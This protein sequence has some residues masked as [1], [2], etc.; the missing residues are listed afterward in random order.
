M[1]ELGIPRP[2]EVPRI[3]GKSSKRDWFRPAPEKGKTTLHKWVCPDCGLNVRI[4]IGSD[5]HLV[6]D[7]CSEIRGEKVFLVR[8]DGL[9]HTIYENK[10][11][12]NLEEA[13][14]PASPISDLVED[15]K[16]AKTKKEKGAIPPI[17]NEINEHLKKSMKRGLSVQGLAKKAGISKARLRDWLKSDS[18]FTTALEVLS[19]TWEPGSVCVKA[20]SWV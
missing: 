10:D 19:T 5:P 3:E 15:T 17:V 8:H 14:R 11:D 7:V 16:T 6:L 13:T 4:G 9:E 12:K 2:D 20:K 18:E 1:G